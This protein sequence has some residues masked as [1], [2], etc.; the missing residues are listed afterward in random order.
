MSIECMAQQLMMKGVIQVRDNED[1]QDEVTRTALSDRLRGLGFELVHNP[2]SNNYGVRLMDD[3]NIMREQQLLSNVNLNSDHAAML[4]ILWLKLL[5]P[6]RV[7]GHPAPDRVHIDAIAEEF[8]HHFGKNRIQG[9]L[10]PLAKAGLIT[11]T[12]DWVLA[13]HNLE[14]AIDGAR[15][16]ALINESVTLME[17]KARA[18]ANIGNS[19]YVSETD[20]VRSFLK[21]A[22]TS[23]GIV[24]IEQTLGL[25]HAKATAALKK[26]RQQGLVEKTGSKFDAK[27]VYTGD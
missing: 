2:Y 25:D 15:M 26:L 18:L 14:T 16:S 1:I 19:E 10:T 7:Q 12:G 27:Y 17:A 6:K 9:I 11:Q 22:D 8:G 4:A 3:P 24:D 5:A 21:E 23:V 20:R 13:G